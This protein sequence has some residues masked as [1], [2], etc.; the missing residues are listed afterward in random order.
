MWETLSSKEKGSLNTSTILFLNFVDHRKRRWEISF[1]VLLGCVFFIILILYCCL[2]VTQD[3]CSTRWP[4]SVRISNSR[5]LNRSFTLEKNECKGDCVKGQ[6]I[7]RNPKTMNVGFGFGTFCVLSLEINTPFL[8]FYW[9]GKNGV[10]RSTFD[11]FTPVTFTVTKVRE[12]M[13]GRVRK[14]ET[15]PY[16][17]GS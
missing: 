8:G 16:V 12:V 2:F 1:G 15:Q 10:I 9:L 5:K 7:N 14:N 11:L 6:I 17:S 13:I 4:D 3:F